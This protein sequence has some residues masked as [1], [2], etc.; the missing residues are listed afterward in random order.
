MTDVIGEACALAITDLHTINLDEPPR[1]RDL[2]LADRLGFADPHKVR[3][4]IQRNRAELESYGEISATVAENT[5]P[6]GRGR[7]G[8]E[9][10]LLEE[11]ALVICA[12]SRTPA[13]MA[14]RRQIITVYA[15]WRRGAGAGAIDAA[16]SPTEQ[17]ILAGIR[18]CVDQRLV[19]MLDRIGA[20]IADA[21]RTAIGPTVDTAINATLIRHSHT[22]DNI[23]LARASLTPRQQDSN[24]GKA[25]AA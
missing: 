6:H 9:Y 5:D 24:T 7:P 14:V 3:T 13:A 11:Q 12:L 23:P 15:Q 22:P 21:L 8:T 16:L 20:D 18:N 10:W 2:A 4:L 17:L 19:S 25:G 1:I